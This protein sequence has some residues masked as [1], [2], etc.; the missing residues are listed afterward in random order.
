MTDQEIG[1]TIERDAAALQLG[2]IELEDVV[3]PA[4]FRDAPPHPAGGHARRMVSRT[5]AHGGTYNLITFDKSEDAGTGG[6][7]EVTS[8]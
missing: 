2:H 6:R 5:I 8:S 4:R 7:I 3:E 1:D